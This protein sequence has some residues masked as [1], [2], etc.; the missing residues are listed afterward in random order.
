MSIA[1]NNSIKESAQRAEINCVT[2]VVGIV[3]YAL[4]EIGGIINERRRK[5]F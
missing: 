3:M 1:E 2:F 4:G 5:P